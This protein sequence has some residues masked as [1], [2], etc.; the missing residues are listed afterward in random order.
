MKKSIS[1]LL[2]LVYLIS[3]QEFRQTLKFPFLIEQFVK[4]EIINDDYT[5]LGFFK[6]HY[7]SGNT[8][9]GDFKEDMKLPFKNI[10]YDFSNHLNL[11]VLNF[12]EIKLEEKQ[13]ITEDI[14]Q[15]FRYKELFGLEFHLKIFEPPENLNR[16]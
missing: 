13:F 11:Y 9:D 8:R 12:S 3:F 15:N 1:I 7:F 10:T 16:L 5:L 2:L 6:H 14:I 4:H